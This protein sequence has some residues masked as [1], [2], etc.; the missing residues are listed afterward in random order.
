MMLLLASPRQASREGPA[1]AFNNPP[2]PWTELE[3]TL[4]G[5]GRTEPIGDGNDSPAWSRKR[6]GYQPPD[7]LRGQRALEDPTAVRVPYAELHCH[8]NFS[9]LDGASH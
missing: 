4:A 5:H 8:S 2:M 6:E 9:F 7:D 3:H 1:V